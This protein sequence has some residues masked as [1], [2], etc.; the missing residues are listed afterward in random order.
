MITEPTVNDM[1]LYIELVDEN[2]INHPILKS[3]LEMIGIDTN[4]LPSN[5]ARFVR[6]T[7]VCG[8]YEKIGSIDYVLY[9]GVYTD[10]Y[11]YV[12]LTEEEKQAKQQRVK[13]EWAAGGHPS[14]IWNEENCKFNPPI[15]KPAD[16]EGSFWSWNEESGIWEDLLKPEQ[17]LSSVDY[18]IPPKPLETA[19]FS[20][21]TGP[22]FT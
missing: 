6:R 20:P 16:A 17:L 8:V 18:S 15:P 12:P 11:H 13:S 3:N 10:K 19:N 9:D 5:Y 14:W 4:N 7:S 1:E 22:K 2:P 21:K